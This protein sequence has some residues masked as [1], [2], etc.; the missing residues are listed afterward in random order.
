MDNFKAELVTDKSTL[1][2]IYPNN[3]ENPITYMGTA[4]H[5]LDMPT[6]ESKYM[7][8]LGW[9]TDVCKTVYGRLFI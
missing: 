1:I 6:I 7:N 8:F 3:G 9:Y 2:T 4:G 5:K